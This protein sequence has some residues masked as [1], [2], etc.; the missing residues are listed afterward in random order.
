MRNEPREAPRGQKARIQE[1]PGERHS[2]SGEVTKPRRTL[3]SVGLIAPAAHAG[4][5]DLTLDEGPELG[6]K[7][8]LVHSREGIGTPGSSQGAGG[9]SDLRRHEP[10]RLP[11]N[12][13]PPMAGPDEGS[14][15][16]GCSTGDRAG[17]PREAEGWGG[18]GGRGSSGSFQDIRPE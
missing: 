7:N 11:W 10:K 12:S 17:E 18:R 16:Q 3:G 2:Q 1:G 4:Q 8:R 9:R 6:A 15:R 13:R 14:C 5:G